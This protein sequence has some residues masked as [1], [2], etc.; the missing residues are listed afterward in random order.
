MTT[1]TVI[2]HN[3]RCSKSRETLKL[4]E[5][6]G[7][8]PVVRLYL[9]EPPQADEIRKALDKL[10]LRPIELM[11]RK[12]AAFK[13]QG[14]SDTMEDELL[15]AA[16]AASPELIERPIVFHNGAA[17]LGRPPQSVAGLFE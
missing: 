16:M 17:A 9:S 13:D 5:D 8:A 2:W 7:V 11:R 3:P 14:L 15:I 1:P 12:D 6:Q 4:L 10:G